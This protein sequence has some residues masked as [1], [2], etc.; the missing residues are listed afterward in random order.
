MQQ[1]QNKLIE[2][3]KSDQGVNSPFPNIKN[4]FSKTDRNILRESQDRRM[5]SE[6]DTRYKI[7]S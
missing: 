7:K 4:I 1:L 2:Q 5:S 3:S 6:S